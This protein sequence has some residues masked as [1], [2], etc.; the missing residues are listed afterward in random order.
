[1]S[2]LL[3]YRELSLP[4]YREYFGRSRPNDKVEKI[5]HLLGETGIHPLTCDAVILW[6]YGEP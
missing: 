3:I 5:L 1:M 2:E 4:R 6:P